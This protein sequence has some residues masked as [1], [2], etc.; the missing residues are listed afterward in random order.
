VLS[1]VLAKGLNLRYLIISLSRLLR[2]ICYHY[3]TQ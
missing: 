1:L 2:T 3:E